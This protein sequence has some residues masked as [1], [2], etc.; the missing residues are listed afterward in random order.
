MYLSIIYSLLYM[1]DHQIQVVKLVNSPQKSLQYS[2]SFIEILL[3]KL[4]FQVMVQVLE[5]EEQ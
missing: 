2:N 1:H 3:S 4:T 5:R